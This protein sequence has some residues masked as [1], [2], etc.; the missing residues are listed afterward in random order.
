M[1][2]LKNTSELLICY[3]VRLLEWDEEKN[4]IITVRKPKFHSDW[5]MKL[6]S[7]I[8]KGKEF[9]IKLDELGSVVWK[10]CDGK[11]T[12]NEIGQLL[13]EH[14]GPDI[15]PIYERLNK[16]LMQLY[17]GKFIEIRCPE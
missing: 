13:G 5:A 9:K 17:R 16:F 4:G 1:S 11:K 3:P 15:E 6:F 12:V 8:L 10:N 14:F 7:P 2:K